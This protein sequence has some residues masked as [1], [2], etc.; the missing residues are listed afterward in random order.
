MSATEAEDAPPD[1]QRQE[2]PEEEAIPSMNSESDAVA[3]VSP[4]ENKQPKKNKKR[5]AY[6]D[7]DDPELGGTMEPQRKL[8]RFYFLDECSR[9]DQCYFMHADFPCKFY[10]FGYECR[11]GKQCRLRHGKALD[12]EMKRILWRHVTTA[13]ANLMQRFPCFPS[14]LLR[15]NFEDRHQE[16]LLMEQEG[17][18]DEDLGAE[19]SE[20]ISDTLL[21]EV[22]KTVAINQMIDDQLGDLGEMAEI[23]SAEQIAMLAKAGIKTKEQLFQLGASSMMELGFDYD[24]IINIGNFKESNRKQSMYEEKSGEEVLANLDEIATELDLSQSLPEPLAV[25]ALS[26]Q[27]LLSILNE[28]QDAVAKAAAAAAGEETPEEEINNT[29]LATTLEGSFTTTDF[30][31]SSGEKV[32][33]GTTDRSNA[34]SL[35]A[36]LLASDMS[37]DG[38]DK[39]QFV[40]FAAAEEKENDPR[41]Q[42]START[43][44]QMCKLDSLI[45]DGRPE[46]NISF[47]SD[48]E[49][50]NS[51]SG[52]RLPF[53][54]IIDKYT[55][56]KEI[57]AGRGQI[58]GYRLIPVDIPKPNFEALRQSFVTEPT[59]SLD[60][61]L[62]LMFNIGPTEV[63]PPA[64][65]TATNGAA[66]KIRDPRLKKAIEVATA[67]G[68]SVGGLAEQ[69]SD[70]EATLT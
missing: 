5:P 10:Y 37:S 29:S 51:Q 63:R 42:E 47:G 43:V 26:D 46:L 38:E 17:L 30:S 69:K 27:E 56:A 32:R 31:D 24:T 57:D 15:K 66:V 62:Q 1:E 40:L 35:E 64:A 34:T 11:D 49:N 28:E 41:A 44:E 59:F 23:I 58:V 2:Q 9:A 55:P 60:P 4:G 54:S 50:S 33:N 25:P 7:L 22:I 70:E 65:V 36:P 12:D 20:S 45:Q 39:L 13:P 19:L 18:L 53:K 67:N 61:R 68:V 48:S 14:A 52:F 3:K 21:G 16:L 6:D 8:C